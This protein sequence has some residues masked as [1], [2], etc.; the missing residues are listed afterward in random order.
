MENLDPFIFGALIFGGGATM[1]ALH[2]DKNFRLK[3]KEQTDDEFRFHRTQYIRRMITSGLI[4]LVGIL[5]MVYRFLPDKSIARVWVIIVVLLLVGTLLVF[6]IIDFF[7]LYR[8][9]QIQGVKTA[10]ATREL[11]DELR[12]LR[13]KAKEKWTK[14]FFFCVYYL[15][16]VC[17]GE[18]GII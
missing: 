15:R 1:M 6:A 13:Q 2:W 5:F 12:R 8:L 11:A 14:M 4:A 16:A 9:R 7:S 17:R 18:G 10:K 3:F